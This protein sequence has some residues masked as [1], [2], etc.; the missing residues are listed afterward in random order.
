MAVTVSHGHTAKW[1]GTFS[2]RHETFIAAVREI[3]AWAAATGWKR[4]LFVNSHFGNDASLRVAVDQI[5]VEHMGTLL[6]GCRNTFSLTPEIWEEFISDA[7]DLHANAAE[8]SMMLHLAPHL[9]RSTEN[10]DDPDRTGNS[11]FSYPVAQTSVNGVTGFPSQA[12]PDAGAAL[13]LQI[14]NALATLLERAITDE[15]PLPP[16]EWSQI[17]RTRGPVF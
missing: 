3:A 6:V 5:R 16:R 11:V 8:T 17:C 10:A 4:L 1:P 9:V 2:L 15:P 7:E 13:F 12:T 14:G